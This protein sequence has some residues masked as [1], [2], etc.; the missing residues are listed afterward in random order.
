MPPNMVK[1]PKDEEKWEKA[2]KLAKEQG[3]ED[4][5]AYIMGIYKRLQGETDEDKELSEMAL[6]LSEDVPLFTEEVDP[7]VS[8]LRGYKALTAL[9]DESPQQRFVRF[10]KLFEASLRNLEDIPTAPIINSIKLMSEETDIQE[11][12]VSYLEDRKQLLRNSYESMKD[13]TQ[14]KVKIGIILGT[15]DRVTRR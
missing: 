1:T 13:W 6:I 12:L 8:I 7:A 3:Q 4:N 5:Y 14:E 10:Q 15:L 11:Q 2:K 9:P